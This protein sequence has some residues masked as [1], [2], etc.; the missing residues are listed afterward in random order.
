MKQYYFAPSPP[1]NENPRRLK[2]RIYALTLRRL[3]ALNV[4]RFQPFVAVDNFEGNLVAFIQCFESR[5]RD[6]SVV[7]KNI[8]PGILGDKA[9]PFFV[10]EPL[11]FATGHNELLNF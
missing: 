6:G 2:H 9:K 10:V 1:A 11:N 5:T 7:Y 4:L 3:D 8:L